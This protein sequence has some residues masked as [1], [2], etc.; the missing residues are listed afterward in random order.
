ADGTFPSTTKTLLNDGNLTIVNLGKEDHGVYECVASNV[1]T[2]VITTALLIIELTTPHA[3]YNLSV[4]TTQYTAK[5]S[6]LPAYD[7]GYPQH[8]VLWYKRKSDGHSA[9]NEWQTL[10][11]V[12]DEAT[13]ITVYE[14]LPNFNYE[15]TVL[16]RNRLGDGLFSK[17]VTARTKGVFS[18][19]HS[20]DARDE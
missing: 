16:S 18:K 2:S 5:V 4:S 8:Y 7:G 11:V 13:S 19:W 15:F 20:Y 3:P 14:L 12:P 1:V 10:R 6:W 17:I 9:R